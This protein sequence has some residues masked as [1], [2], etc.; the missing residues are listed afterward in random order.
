MICYRAIPIIG[1][2]ACLGITLAFADPQARSALV[3]SIVPILKRKR[4]MRSASDEGEEV[5]TEQCD[6]EPARDWQLLFQEQVHAEAGF[7]RAHK[8]MRFSQAPSYHRRRYAEGIRFISLPKRSKAPERIYVRRGD[9][10]GEHVDWG[11]CESGQDTT[12][13]Q[14]PSHSRS[15]P[16]SR[17]CQKEGMHGESYTLPPH[18]TASQRVAHTSPT[19]RCRD[20]EYLL[21]AGTSDESLPTALLVSDAEEGQI[22]E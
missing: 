1:A 4:E 6:C 19:T 5:Q 12:V 2:A 9:K 13:S 18:L 8:R 22:D 10:P 14:P 21:F 17:L 3:S 15:L 11:S 7:E 16:S 20:G